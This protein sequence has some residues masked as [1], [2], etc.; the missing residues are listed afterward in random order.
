MP[1]APSQSAPDLASAP[2]GQ[3]NHS[4]AFKIATLKTPRDGEPKVATYTLDQL[5]QRVSNAPTSQMRFDAYHFQKSELKR[6]SAEA[7]A[8]QDIGDI[9]TA[10]SLKFQ[11]K[12]YKDALDNT[13]FGPAIM[14]FIFEDDITFNVDPGG[15]KHRD[16]SRI[17]HFSLVMLD[18]ES[19]TSQEEI[20]SALRDYEYLLW[21]T[22]SHTPSDPRYRVVLFPQ[23]PLTIPESQALIH[24]IDAHLPERNDPRKKTQ[25]VDPVSDEVGRLMFL[26]RWLIGHPEKYTIVH[27]AG[28]L[29]TPD[30]FAV[31]AKVQAAI[32]SRRRLV[33]EQREKEKTES[34]AR[35][36][37]GT[38]PDHNGNALITVKGKDWLNPDYNFETED[39]FVQ[40]KDVTTK[41]GGVR[42]PFHND[43]VGSEFI[44]PNKHSGRPQ[45]VCAKCGT[46][47]ML[48]YN[49]DWLAPEMDSSEFAA[50][51][52]KAK[53]GKPSSITRTA[54]KPG[55]LSESTVPPDLYTFNSRYL[56][57][58]H[59][60]LPEQGILFVRSPKGTGKTEA[61][62]HVVQQARKAK[63]SVVLLTHRRSLAKNLSERLGL[64]NY[65]D[66]EDG[67]V[68]SDYAVVCVNS[69]T[70]R[71][72][73]AAAQ[74]DIVIIDESE[75][76]LRNLLASTL[77]E[78]LSDVFNKILLLLSN[79]LQVICL[80]ADLS[81][82]M[83]MEI[84]TLMRDSA[85]EKTR[86]RY[87]GI[88]NEY[89]IGSGKTIR[90]LP[91]QYQLLAEIAAA[92]E[93][94]QK[95][96]VASSTARAATAIGEM[97]KEQGKNV[98]VITA[99]TSDDPAVRYFQAHPNKVLAPTTVVKEQMVS[100]NGL[101]D[102][103]DEPARSNEI[104]Q[105]DNVNHYDAVIA[106]PSLQTGF[107]IDVPYFDKVFGWFQS[108]DGI[109]YQDYD[110]ALSRVRH[111][112]DVTIWMQKTSLP[113]NIEPPEAFVQKAR[114][115]ELKDRKVLPGQPKTLD[116]AQQL[117]VRIE[118]LIQYLTATWCSWRDVKFKAMKEGLG[119]KVKDITKD[120]D[121]ESVG[122]D[123]W[124]SFKDAGP[125]YAQQIL[126]APALNYDE[127]FEVSRKQHKTNEEHFAL[128]RYRIA[129]HVK[130]DLTLPLV[131][132]AI[133]E[134]IVRVVSRVR[135]LII[136]G[137]ATRAG[138]DVESR[139][140]HHTAFTKASHRTV[141]HELLVKHLCKAVD[142]DLKQ[143]YRRIEA[144]EE[145]MI[146]TDLLDRLVEAYVQ[147]QVD[148]AY[149]FDLRI[150]SIE[151]AVN[152]QK[153]IAEDKELTWT[154]EDEAAAKEKAKQ[155]RRKHV[156]NGT[157]GTL[158]L[159][160]KKRKRGPRGKQV[161]TY[162][163]D[164]KAVDLTTKAIR[165]QERISEGANAKLKLKKRDRKS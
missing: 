4:L 67:S 68:I 153:R 125:D 27:N 40:L 148:F 70:S 65:Q 163:I 127:F 62:Y 39:G 72:D 142:L 14:P 21:P 9:R 130:E 110:Q 135:A 120:E 71:L 136:E 82:D 45:L 157:L 24:R 5:V 91:N 89:K 133:K 76:V 6:L 150:Q 38:A 43:A 29:L 30:S 152:A 41:V 165:E 115:K 13:K 8:A 37:S 53:S 78:N 129:G 79:A 141:E 18:I 66:L 12:R 19:K 84:I 34:M 94:G 87:I 122:R 147:R 11:S 158:G 2:L 102:I 97:L 117:W 88:T 35:H 36:K 7:K 46:F 81:S 140:H 134:D 109:T 113:A 31:T 105:D 144:S 23:S 59:P 137:D 116:D 118:G 108:V 55:H 119:F 42:C 145:V 93:A 146:S 28:K 111:C 3:S 56:P 1:A 73:E 126:D 48:P 57:D 164:N 139:E 64:H 20:H 101:L 86:D 63:R 83:T 47:K 95:F 151:S 26:P 51:I 75:Q 96:F 160:L 98:L 69:L 124:S 121:Q 10:K 54:K 112:D 159:P 132:K 74:Y 149:F 107:S 32:D 85:G 33:E 156:W 104:T 22:I 154:A 90:Y 15:V 131:E 162:F 52:Q 77:K 60:L 61:L 50:L 99:Q 44:A 161:A 106:S 25:N 80:D 16:K 143:V 58:I 128:R 155:H 17:T 103:D 92:A 114:S 123:L 138:Y 100:R 49:P